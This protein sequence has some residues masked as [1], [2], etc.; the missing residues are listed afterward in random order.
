MI[1]IFLWL[2]LAFARDCPYKSK[3]GLIDKPIAQEARGFVV[4][5]REKLL[6]EARTRGVHPVALAGVFVAE[7]SMN[8]RLDDEIQDLFSSV[9]IPGFA[10]L[11]FSS[12]PGQIKLS[13]AIYTEEK[14]AMW[15]ERDR[16]STSEVRLLLQ[17]PD[18]SI[19]YAAAILLDAQK[20]FQ[21]YGV[22]IS[23]QPEILATVYNVGVDKLRLPSHSAPQPNYFGYYVQLHSKEINQMLY[24]DD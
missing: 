8:V 21:E 15:D 20:V 5:H 2:S 10:P 18:G 6:L 9:T 1:Y 16:R 22:D 7:H 17:T 4:E 23:Q 24:G 3:C 19:E 14:L 13:T 12:G 11:D